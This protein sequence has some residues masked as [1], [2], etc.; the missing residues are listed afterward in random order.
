[1]YGLSVVNVSTTAPLVGFNITSYVCFRIAG[2]IMSLVL[3]PEL[4]LR[5]FPQEVGSPGTDKIRFQGEEGTSAP[6]SLRPAGR[7]T[8]SGFWPMPGLVYFLPSGRA[9]VVRSWS[10]SEF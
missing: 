3:R 5:L 10:R 6:G 2:R 9:F 4:R 1:M 7:I 8:I